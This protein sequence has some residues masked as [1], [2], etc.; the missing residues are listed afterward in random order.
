MAVTKAELARQLLTLEARKNYVL[1][2]KATG[3]K[4]SMAVALQNLKDHIQAAFAPLDA[5]NAAKIVSAL[6]TKI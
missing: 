6:P 1:Q 5:T 3:D 4:A 2:Y